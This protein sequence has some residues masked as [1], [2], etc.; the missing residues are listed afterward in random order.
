MLPFILDSWTKNNNS[1]G[2]TSFHDFKMF[3]YIYILK[4][5]SYLK[6]SCL[7]LC[8]HFLIVPMWVSFSFFL[9]GGL[10]WYIWK[11]SKLLQHLHLLNNLLKSH[12]RIKIIDWR[13]QHLKTF[14]NYKSLKQAFVFKGD[15]K[16]HINHNNGAK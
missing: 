4:E 12:G 3:N 1:E 13:A 15:Y 5:I 9:G 7:H 11:Y 6:K 8:F 14:Y 16:W 2:S 10:D